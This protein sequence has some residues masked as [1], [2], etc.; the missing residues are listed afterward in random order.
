MG[1]VKKKYLTP[2]PALCILVNGASGVV[3]GTYC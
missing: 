3:N 2:L 1:G